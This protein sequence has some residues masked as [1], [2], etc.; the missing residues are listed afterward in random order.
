MTGWFR[1]AR[2]TVAHARATLRR[3]KLSVAA[4]AIL[5]TAC[6]VAADDG[7]RPITIIAPGE[8]S[9][10]EKLVLG[11]LGGA[12]VVAGALGLYFHLDA[13]STGDEVATDVF[14]GKPWTTARQDTVDSANSSRF[15]AIAL[16]GVGGAFLAGAVIYWIVTEPPD[17][18]IVI[19]P[20]AQPTVAPT[21][22]GALVGGT[23]SF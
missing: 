5:A 2:L 17:E 21:P 7:P 1:Q 4:L 22:G 23:W 16:Y 11:G 8:R 9:T 12:A 15:T 20:R 18:T 10:N 3:M 19:R 13:R 14:T 6:P